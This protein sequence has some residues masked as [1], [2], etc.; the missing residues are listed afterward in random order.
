MDSLGAVRKL[1]AQSRHPGSPWCSWRGG[2]SLTPERAWLSL[3]SEMGDMNLEVLLLSG[4]V[5][6][7]T[8]TRHHV[9]K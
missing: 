9:L 6:G 4:G 2:D 5:R 1:G 7:L 8:W 3:A